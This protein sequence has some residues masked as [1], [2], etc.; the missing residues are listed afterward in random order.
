MEIVL[1]INWEQN[2]SAA[3]IIDGVVFGCSSEERF[4]NTKN[5][6]SYPINAINWLI[7]EAKIRAE[8][9]NKVAFISEFWSPT[10]SLIRHYTSFSVKD[11]IDEQDLVW[12]K[13]IYDNEKVNAL[14]VFEHKI[15]YLQFPGEAFWKSVFHKLKD[16]SD[17][18]SNV[19]L[20]EIG[21]KIR[22]QVVFEHLSIPESRIA[23]ID[24]HLGHGAYAYFSA[25]TPVECLVLT[26]DAFGDFRNYCAY[27]AKRDSRDGSV[28]F[29]EV[30]S[31]NN[32]IVGRLYR[33]VTL[34]LNMKPNEHEY[35]VM[36]LAPYGK[37]E[38]AEDVLKIFRNYQDVDGV[39]F[40]D[41]NFPKDLYFQVKDDLKGC[42]FDAIA[43]GLQIYTEELILAWVE[44]LVIQTGISNIVIGG[45]VAMN[46]KANSLISKSSLIKSLYIPP[47]PDDSSQSM[48]AAYVANALLGVNKNKIEFD[49]SNFPISN[50]Y[51]GRGFNSDYLTEVGTEFSLLNGYS[52]QEQGVGL[53]AK[54]L[55]E[56]LILGRFAGRAE[57]GARALGNRSILANPG[58]PS[59]KKVIN[60]KIKN[61]DFWMP[62]AAT[63][64]YEY[65]D[66]YLHL[67]VEKSSYAY[68][69][70]ACATTS[71]GAKKLSAAIHPYDESCRPQILKKQM[72]PS[73]WDLIHIFGDYTGTYA[74]LNTSLNFHGKPIV[75]DV[76]EALQLLRDSNLDG[77]LL[78]N[79][80]IYKT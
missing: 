26:I 22:S 29:D 42:R 69:T 66:E 71:V 38:Y 72:N 6:E 57:F 48:G 12:R 70:N 68:M 64:L 54:L 23:F 31:G 16:S 21:K 25:D 77:M 44:N 65:A 75:G 60:E 40:R 76:H 49:N 63:V 35:K 1:G 53:A 4:T 3:L 13:R 14:K 62:F 50:A 43:T 79:F 74:L 67:D 47:S 58:D 11:F 37:S 28:S 55:S 18:V 52:F 78:D 45:G 7:S 2:S 34:I 15:D 20:L 36:G 10:Y 24:H 27:V 33:Y 56:G 30:S 9:I 8:D 61:R 32:F 46:V 17:H 41:V 19:D 51:L 80:L 5:D 39:K 59:I 73:Y